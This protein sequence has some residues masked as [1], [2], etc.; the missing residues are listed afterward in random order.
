MTHNDDAASDA[1]ASTSVVD[2]GSD[3][4]WRAWSRGEGG[5]GGLHDERF[6]LYDGGSGNGMVEPGVPEDGRTCDM[7]GRVQF[8]DTRSPRSPRSRS[9]LRRTQ[10]DSGLLIHRHALP[11]FFSYFAEISTRLP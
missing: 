11:V 4:L 2:V 8:L 5:G 6:M 10:S 7:I 3:E 1:L 9:C